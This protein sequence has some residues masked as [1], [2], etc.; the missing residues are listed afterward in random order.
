MKNLER[1][2]LTKENI[3][4]Y[5]ST[6]TLQR[7]D[8]TEKK[9]NQN[10]RKEIIKKNKPVEYFLPNYKDKL[11]WCFY[12]V[13]MVSLNMKMYNAFTE[14]KEKNK[15]SPNVTRKKIVKKHKFK[16]S[17]VE[18]NLTNDQCINLLIHL[19]VF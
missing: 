16:K 11:F 13:F 18:P 10:E 6:F 3:D 7:K 17:H 8:R 2:M 15:I 5:L 4:Y 14:E 1:N 12:Y 19:F 9:N